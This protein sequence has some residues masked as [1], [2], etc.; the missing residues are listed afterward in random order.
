MLR[1]RFLTTRTIEPVADLGGTEQAV[2]NLAAALR[3]RGHDVSMGTGAMSGADVCVAVNDA[4]LLPDAPGL[5]VVWFHNEVSLWRECRRGRLAALWRTR[6]VAVFLGALQAKQAPALPLFRRRVVILHGVPDAMLRAPPAEWPPAPQAVFLSQAYRG[7]KEVISVWRRSVAPAMPGARLSAFVQPHEIGRY[8]ALARGEAS[9]AI[10][11]RV[12][13]AAIRGVLRGARVVLA[14]GHRSETFCLVAAEAAAMGVPVV[15]RGWG[16]L[17]E[18]VR[19]GET[20]FVCGSWRGF[21][22]RTLE[23]LGDDEL[24]RRL[25]A[26]GLATREAAGWDRAARAWETLIDGG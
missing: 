5:P 6:P 19:D 17:A 11:A 23:L 4:R 24:W 13:H 22:R 25:Q 9:I 15:T 3:A 26:G 7:L 2:L 8:R 12:A 21:A 1:W 18:R 20:G 14:P 10:Q 16:A